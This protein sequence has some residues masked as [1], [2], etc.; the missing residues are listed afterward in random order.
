[1]PLDG[2]PIILCY[3]QPQYGSL[4]SA[5]G[6][7]NRG[8]DDEVDTRRAPRASSRLNSLSDDTSDSGVSLHDTGHP[9]PLPPPM[10]PPTS[11]LLPS[12][13]LPPP[14]LPQS[15][16]SPLQRR[17]YHPT[18]PGSL[19]SAYRVLRWCSS[20]LLRADGRTL[21][22]TGNYPSVL[23]YERHGVF[24]IEIINTF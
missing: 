3:K 20:W 5:R 15:H 9:D 21:S 19:H 17:R 12:P 22:T 1:M 7:L 13:R 4:R 10:L 16:D 24:H 11:S 6:P 14:L 2:S 23:R 8:T 18:R